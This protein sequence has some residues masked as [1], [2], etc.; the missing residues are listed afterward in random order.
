MAKVSR[1]LGFTRR[2]LL[3]DQAAA[4]IVRL[5]A[6]PL[7]PDEV[8]ALRE[9]LAR[10]DNHRRVLLDTARVWDR[11]DVMAA[12]AEI[13]NVDGPARRSRSLAHITLPA[14]AAG[15]AAVAVIA[16]LRL[17]PAPAVV[18][19]TA[20]AVAVRNPAVLRV[21]ETRIGA[22]EV[23]RLEDG[24]VIN[25]NTAT[26]LSVS[27]SASRR[28]VTLHSGEAYFDVA[29]NEDAAFIVNVD[30]TEI[31]ALGTA[32]SVQKLRDGVEVTVAEGLVR[33]QRDWEP[34]VPDSLAEPA[35]VLLRAGQ[36][37]EAGP[38]GV[39]EIR[40]LDPQ[41]LAR[42][43]LW[44]QKILAFDGNT[45]QEVVDEYSRYTPLKI[46]IADAET[47]NI[48]VGGYF[49]S[50]NIAGLL[51]SLEQNFAI[52]VRQTASNS[53]VLQRSKR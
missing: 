30:D 17:P 29:R 41:A 48:R 50:D 32:F 44:Q 11:M 38:P 6:G 34:A 43:L 1:I 52:S 18:P 7:A 22:T 28:S 19:A 31:S 33:V 39:Q 37:F 3:H 47:A 15:L 4:W 45:L 40:E 5:D 16:Y 42:K 36:A 46:T 2:E 12:L 13:L 53:F 51:T 49:R 20:A 25:L 8:N 26:R 35:P 27:L 14:L 10:S 21:Y 23:V 9:W 24:T